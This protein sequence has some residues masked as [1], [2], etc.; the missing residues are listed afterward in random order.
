MAS[1]R[2]AGSL[3][4]GFVPQPVLPNPTGQ[5]YKT[6]KPASQKRFVQDHPGV[7][8]PKVEKNA[9]WRVFSKADFRV[10]KLK[11]SAEVSCSADTRLS[12]FTPSPNIYCAPAVC[13]SSSRP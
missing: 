9:E 1:W 3:A 12:L 5:S 10:G 4:R 7:L 11:Q 13:T 2:P 6:Q 8:T